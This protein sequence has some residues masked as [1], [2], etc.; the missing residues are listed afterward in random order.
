MRNQREMIFKKWVDDHKGLIFKVVRSFGKTFQDQDDLFQDICMQLWRSIPNFNGQASESTWIY[1]VAFNTALSV[2]RKQKRHN[3][4]QHLFTDGREVEHKQ[5]IENDENIEKLYDA[6]RELPKTDRSLMLMHLDGLTHS[7]IADVL[8]ISE[9]NVGV[10][11]HRSKKSL[12]IKLKGL[13]DDI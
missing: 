6:I 7:Q 3:K 4:K 9:N 1:R 12:A 8:G 2:N 5:K 11:L 13:I 10:K